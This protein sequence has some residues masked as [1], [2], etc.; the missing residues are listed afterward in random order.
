GRR[1]TVRTTTQQTVPFGVALP[2]S[3]AITTA[4]ASAS[5]P[6]DAAI[7]AASVW[8]SSQRSRSNG[9]EVY[10]SP[11]WATAW[12]R[13]TQSSHAPSVKCQVDERDDDDAGE[14]REHQ[15]EQRPA[16]EHVLACELGIDHASS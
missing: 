15:A 8:T 13:R 1:H 5:S 16:P 10:W 7:S 3:P 14:E 2:Y 9:V 4:G 12:S 11:F 6:P